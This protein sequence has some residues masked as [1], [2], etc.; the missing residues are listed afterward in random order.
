MDICSI[1]IDSSFLG[2]TPKERSTKG[3]TTTS[4]PGWKRWPGLLPKNPSSKRIQKLGDLSPR[5][6]WNA[7]NYS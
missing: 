4:Q 3:N 6:S 1:F 5:S 2:G 7:I